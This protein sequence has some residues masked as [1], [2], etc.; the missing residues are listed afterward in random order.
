MQNLAIEGVI[1]PDT[2]PRLREVS[3]PLEDKTIIGPEF[4]SL[5]AKMR[6]MMLAEGGIGLAA[7]Q[8]GLNLRFFIVEVRNSRRYPGL[9]NIPLQVFINPRIIRV[10][11][12]KGYFV[13]GCLSVKDCRISL[14]R[15]KTLIVEYTDLSGRVRNRHLK[16]LEARIFQHEYDHLDGILIS[17]YLG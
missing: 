12:R 5:V 16:G 3:E 15:P 1:L 6:K 17:D 7:P 8:V 9:P 13:E 2:D 4:K 14:N 10:A 11:K